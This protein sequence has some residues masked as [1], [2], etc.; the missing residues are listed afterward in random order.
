MSDNDKKEWQ[1]EEQER[2]PESR[3]EKGDETEN[4][5]DS[6]SENER[7]K[8]KSNSLWDGKNLRSQQE[9]DSNIVARGSMGKEEGKKQTVRKW[10]RIVRQERE[11][12]GGRDY[13]QPGKP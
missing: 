8:K 1:E 9:L 5:G 4:K 11:V 12:R 7:S 2:E 10:K 6:G 13:N 3:I